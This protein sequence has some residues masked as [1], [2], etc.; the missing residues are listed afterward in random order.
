MFPLWLSQGALGNGIISLEGRVWASVCNPRLR[1]SAEECSPVVALRKQPATNALYTLLNVHLRSCDFVVVLLSQ[2]TSGSWAG[3][4][5]KCL[6]LRAK[7]GYLKGLLLFLIC[8]EASTMP[9]F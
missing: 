4:P 5:L 6:D 7:G 9:C 1:C 8:F 2:T 3:H